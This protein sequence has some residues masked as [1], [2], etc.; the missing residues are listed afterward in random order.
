MLVEILIIVIMI[1]I[2]FILQLYLSILELATMKPSGWHTPHL[3][4]N[5]DTLYLGNQHWQYQYWF[6]TF[7]QFCVRL[8]VY[9]SLSVSVRLCA[10][11]LKFL[12]TH[13]CEASADLR[14][15]NDNASGGLSCHLANGGK[16]A[17]G[18]SAK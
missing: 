4:D 18:K 11:H 10:I 8:F 16:L 14:M 2:C 6:F 9:M 3:V 13:Y 5:T 17:I 15:K 1:I 12:E 7:L